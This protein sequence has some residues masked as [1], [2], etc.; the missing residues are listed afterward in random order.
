MK[1]QTVIY[2]VAIVIL[3][4][5]YYFFIYKKNQTDAT[6][7]ITIPGG[8]IAAPV[9]Q[10]AVING[11]PSILAAATAASQTLSTVP[12]VI[13]VPAVQPGVAAPISSSQY[14]ATILPWLNSLGV[15][16]KQQALKMY[17][18][19]TEQEK[20]SLAD[21][22]ANVW[23]GKRAQTSADTIFWNTWRTKY[24]ILDGTYSPFS[25]G[26]PQTG[27]AGTNSFGEQDAYV[28]HDID[29]LAPVQNS[30]TANSFVIKGSGGEAVNNF[31][32]TKKRK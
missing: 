32:R 11:P 20:A 19:M 17:P 25:G 15:A 27:Y 18:S 1:K 9:T 28:A 21:I 30:Q 16:N 22:I 31:K 29:P 12:D 26:D 10:A 5:L 24:H 23:G 4:A 3:A 8:P 7:V 2:I 14:D 13:A 6:A